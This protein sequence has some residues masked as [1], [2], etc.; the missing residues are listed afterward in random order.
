MRLA[1]YNY[2]T[3]TSHPITDTNKSGVS[4]LQEKEKKEKRALLGIMKQRSTR[5][6]AKQSQSPQKAKSQN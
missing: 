5:T 4:Y 2:K 3:Q 1:L 6:K